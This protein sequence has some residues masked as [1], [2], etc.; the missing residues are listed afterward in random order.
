MKI[1][2]AALAEMAEAYRVF[3]PYRSV[4][5]MTMFGSARTLPADP[6]YVLARDLATRLAEQ[7]PGLPGGLG[8]HHPSLVGGGLGNIA[9]R[10]ADGPADIRGLISRDIRRGRLR[11]RS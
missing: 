10:L 8:Y 2:D 3:G 7:V 11:L 1:A 4:R 6:V 5:K 9:A